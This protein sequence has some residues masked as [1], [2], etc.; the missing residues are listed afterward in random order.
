MAS[1]GTRTGHPVAAPDTYDYVIVGAGTA[2]C[3]LANRLSEDPEV[4]VCLIEAGPP[5]TH[6]FIHV[7]ALV[8]A[9][10]ATKAINWGFLT[11]PQAQLHN[12]LIPVPRGRVL[13]GTG[14]INGMAYFRGQPRDFDDWAAAGNAGWSWRE[15][16]PYFL[17]SENNPDTPGLAVSRHRRPDLRRPYPAAQPAERGVPRGLR[18]IG[19]Y[20]RCADFN[21]ASPEGY[22]MRQ[23]TIRDGRRDSTANGL[24][25]ARLCPREPDGADPCACDAHR[26]RRAARGRRCRAGREHL[27][28]PARRET[29][30]CAGAIGHRSY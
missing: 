26:D 13:G 2:G 14:S 20:P 18:G 22:G 3:V 5:D 23:G 30:L 29:L 12:R 27:E 7:P 28:Y 1:A 24:P 6:P 10:I 8:G 9:A 11:A 17:R 25:R 16:L 21:G 4:Q 19:G 15:V